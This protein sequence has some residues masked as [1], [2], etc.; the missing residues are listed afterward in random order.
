MRFWSARH[1]LGRQL[2]A[3]VAAR[4]HDAVGQRDDAVQVLDRGR[5]LELGQ[6]QARVPISARASSMSS[7]RC[8][9]ESATQSTPIASPKARSSRS[10]AVSG[11]IGS[12]TLGTLTPLRSEIGPPTSTVVSAKSAPWLS[13][14]RR[15]LPSS[16]S[17]S[18]PTCSAA[19][20]SGCSSGARRASPGR[21][22]MSRRKSRAGFELR[23]AAFES[24]QAQLRPLQVE[25]HADRPAEL[26]LQ[27]ADG[28]QAPR[29]VGLRAVA[30]VEPEHVHAVLEQGA[31]GPLVGRGRPER[32]DDLGA[33]GAS[34]GEG[35][36]PSREGG[37]GR[38][39]LPSSWPA[40]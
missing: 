22:S 18:V 1:L 31:D 40:A 15:S 3:E 38:A 5:L 20:I 35:F 23:P 33:A 37:P 36:T 8:T 32:G 10:F 17:S 30:E 16:S 9:K 14:R 13:T 26:L 25:Q 11:E 2:D 12:S 24:A 29:V 7:G 34:H 27:R 19:K 39:D 6:I 21:L 4:D 28:F